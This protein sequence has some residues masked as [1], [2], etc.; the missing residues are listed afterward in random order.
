[1][2]GSNHDRFIYR[3]GAQKD[4]EQVASVMKAAFEGSNEM[5]D[6]ARMMMDGSHASSRAEHTALV[7]ERTTGRIAAAI[8][9]APQ[10]WYY[11][12]VPLKALNISEVGTH[13][14][15]QG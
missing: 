10:T 2:T 1:M 11:E 5:A 13:P 15:F 6:W 14:N 8:T 7:E 3:W 9:T 4:I 12:K